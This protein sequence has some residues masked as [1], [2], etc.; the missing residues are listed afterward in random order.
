[1]I[2]VNMKLTAV[3]YTERIKFET[4]VWNFQEFVPEAG[5]DIKIFRTSQTRLFLFL[6]KFK[7]PLKPQK[8]NLLLKE[9]VS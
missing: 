8:L 7:K 3:E 5:K 6:L 4:S 2:N 1:M 9:S